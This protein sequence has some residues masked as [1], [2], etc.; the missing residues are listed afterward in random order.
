[1]ICA[2]I[3]W[4]P[5]GYKK[6]K[7]FPVKAVYPVADS[8]WVIIEFQG[9]LTNTKTGEDYGNEY[10]VVVQIRDSRISLFLEFFD[11]LQR[12]AFEN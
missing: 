2:T 5:K 11:S 8:E 1:M 7:G 6:P 12:K 4:G 9:H 10:I 3:S